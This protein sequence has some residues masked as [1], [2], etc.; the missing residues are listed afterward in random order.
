MMG[1][2]TMR[3]PMMGMMSIRI[4]HATVKTGKVELDVT[5][6][7]R[8]VLH[9]VLLVPVDSP[10]ASLPYDYGTGRVIEDQVRVLADSSELQPSQ[11]KILDVDLQPGAY[12]LLCN[13]PRPL[14]VGHGDSVDRDALRALA[15]SDRLGRSVRPCPSRG[16]VM[17]SMTPRLRRG[18]TSKS[19]GDPGIPCPPR[20][21]PS[22]RC[23]AASAISRPASH[24]SVGAI[25]HLPSTGSRAAACACFDPLSMA[26]LSCCTPPAR[27]I[28]SP[29]PRSSP[30]LITATPWR[31]CRPVSGIYPKAAL[32]ATLRADPA[33]LEA[34]TAELARRLQALRSRLE[35]RDIRSARERVLQ[36]LASAAAGTDGRSIPIEGRLQDIAADLGLT[37]EAFYR[38][39]AA[40]EAEGRDHP[41]R[42]LDRAQRDR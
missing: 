38:T 11:S 8:S 22:P 12:L 16:S 31:P 37:R 6:W 36:H 32:L 41:H 3:G 30:R 17:G 26:A 25:V 34:F 35:L 23:P 19:T 33:L 9:E 21:R 4:D 39:L 20:S 1:R 7:S 27:A 14:C 5:N 29:R 18:Q 15:G 13:V 2:G 40:L 28:C 42:G 10:D 24:S